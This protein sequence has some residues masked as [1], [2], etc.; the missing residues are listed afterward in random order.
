MNNRQTILGLALGLAVLASSAAHAEWRDITGSEK[1]DLT[2]VNGKVWLASFTPDSFRGWDLAGGESTITLISK[3]K[4][5]GW[6]LAFDADGK[7][8]TVTLT[9]KRGPGTV[10]KRTRVKGTAKRYTI[11]ATSGKYKGWYL[12]AGKAETV[13][14][15]RGNKRTVYEA[16]LVK[17]P[18]KPLTFSI[19]E[20][21]H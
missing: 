14:T 20:V 18:K 16:V 5:S 4:W 1:G 9:S 10:W 3:D 8:P 19:Y 15:K 2:V 11:Q 7:D 6:N 12:D 13:V 21:G 17:E